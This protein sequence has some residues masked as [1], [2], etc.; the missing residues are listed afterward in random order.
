M[1]VI[2]LAAAVLTLAGCS[3]HDGD[4]PSAVRFMIPIPED[5]TLSAFTVS[6]DGRWL[7]YSAERSQDGLRVLFL[8]E[9]AQGAGSDRELPNTTGASTP[10]FSPDGASVAYFSRGSIWRTSVSTLQLP[11]RVAEAPSDSAGGTWTPD[12]RIIFAPLGNLGLVQV[13]ATGGTAVPLTSLNA[14][15][16]ELDHGWPHALPD[17]AIVFTVSQRGRDPHVEVLLSDNTRQRLRVPIIGQAQFVETGHL[18]YSYLGNLM[19]VK[20]D[21][22]EHTTSDVPVAIAKGI[23][24]SSGFGVLGR[25]GFSVSRTGTLAWLRSSPDDARSRVVRVDREGKVAPLQMSAETFQTPRISPD[26]R[27][28]AVVVRSGVMTREIRVADAARPDPSTLTISG[29]DNQSPAWMDNRRLTFGSNREGLQKI[30]VVRVDSKRAPTSLFTADATAAR[31]PA[32]WSR[33]PRLLALYEIEPTRGRDVLVYRIRESVAPV[34]ATPANERSPTVSPDARWIAFVSDASGRDEVYAT[35]LDRSAETLQ[36]TSEG[37]TE[38]VWTREGL[39]YRQGE[40]MM[41]RVVEKD[42]LTD[43]RPVFEGHFERDPGANAAAYDV[44]LQGRFVMLK[45]ALKPREVRIVQNWGAE[46][47]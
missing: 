22:E 29:G 32:S 31:N 18:V 47:P 11:Q 24:T 23:Q 3:M 6:A 14:A 4:P 27:R 26:G 19:G 9:I 28:L 20:F 35:R 45:S 25:S 36:L 16:G 21:L 37:A 42:T 38:P 41:L 2:A 44:D 7:A 10:F 40:R 13:A 12:G 8:R 34:A 39:F 43:A 30:Y 33:P 1:A 46:L 5:R 15:D 17:G